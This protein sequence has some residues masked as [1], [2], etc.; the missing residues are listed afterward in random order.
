VRRRAGPRS[1]A[2]ADDERDGLVEV[3]VADLYVRQLGP[4]HSGVEEQQMMA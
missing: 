1:P 2:L 4:P 3:D